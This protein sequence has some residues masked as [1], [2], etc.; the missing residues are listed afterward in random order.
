M[1]IGFSMPVMQ[2]FTTEKN[3]DGYMINTEATLDTGGR[4]D[5][6]TITR[7]TGQKELDIKHYTRGSFK[8]DHNGE[9]TWAE[10][11]VFEQL[12]NDYKSDLYL[13]LELI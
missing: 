8:H 10:M 11:T 2:T 3:E 4:I 13:Q 7:V 12:N 5:K 9:L 6:N 1:G